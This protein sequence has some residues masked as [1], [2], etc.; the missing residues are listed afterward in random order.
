MNEQ[1]IP[2]FG[3]GDLPGRDPGDWS[4][5]IHQPPAERHPDDRSESEHQLVEG[6][7]DVLALHERIA[8]L[9]RTVDWQR[10]ELMTERRLRSVSEQDAETARRDAETARLDGRIDK[11]TGVWKEDE[12]EP[13]IEKSRSM[14]Q[15]HG[16]K[17]VVTYSDLDN[18]HGVNEIDGEEVGDKVIKAIAH[19]KQL[20]GRVGMDFVHRWDRGDEL[21]EVLTFIES[22]PQVVKNIMAKRQQKAEQRQSA[23]AQA[24]ASVTTGITSGFRI[25]GPEDDPREVVK[26]IAK[27]VKENKN[28]KGYD[29]R[30]PKLRGAEND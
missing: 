3:E 29:R 22:D 4:E 17:V 18:L 19:D 23:T 13:N 27:E 24:M 25:L 28:K 11:K 16:G 10:K 7:E 14:A 26:E 8:E 30:D 9:E 12:F 2:V 21:V 20:H 5:M 6:A 1:S 15:K